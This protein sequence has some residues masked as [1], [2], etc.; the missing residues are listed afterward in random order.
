MR[1]F[2]FIASVFFAPRLVAA[3][4]RFCRGPNHINANHVVD[5]SDHLSCQLPGRSWDCTG[6]RAPS[7]NFA[8]PPIDADGDVDLLTPRSYLGI[9]ATGDSYN[10]LGHRAN[11]G[12]HSRAKSRHVAAPITFCERV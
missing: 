2:L 12:R 9:S 10:N 4:D 1:C 5:L 11:R 8:A 3:T 7:Q 6:S